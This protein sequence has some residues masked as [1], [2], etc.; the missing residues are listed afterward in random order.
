[1][2]VT[3]FAKPHTVTVTSASDPTI[4]Y[5]LKPM[6]NQSDAQKKI[7]ETYFTPQ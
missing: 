2:T 5:A 7:Y 6:Q 1:L 4:T 3:R